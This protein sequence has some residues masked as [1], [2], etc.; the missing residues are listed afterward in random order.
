VS[1][2]SR[3]PFRALS[4]SLIIVA[5][6][7]LSVFAFPVQPQGSLSLAWD[8]STDPSV[9]G[10]R[11]YLGCASQM[12]TNVTDVAGLATITISNL[13]PST[14]YYFAVTAYY[15]TGLESEFSGEISY[16]VPTSAVLTPTSLLRWTITKVP[17]GHVMLTGM[18]QSG[19]IYE[20]WAT[21]DLVSWSLIGSVVTGA[22]GAFEFSDRDSLMIPFR[23]Y[24]LS[25]RPNQPSALN[26]LR[27]IPGH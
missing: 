24:R 10:Y 2:S 27:S 17:F 5:A 20:I 19:W 7:K 4:V 25:Q 3:L 15:E 23:F 11:L 16:T 22:S 26:R 18:G 12:Y 21:Q 6:L 14:T 8:P 13:I 1:R 9:V